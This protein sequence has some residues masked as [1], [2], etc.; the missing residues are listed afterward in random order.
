MAALHM[1]AVM[2]ALAMVLGMAAARTAAAM[3][4]VR[5]AAA[6][7]VGTAVTACTEED[8]HLVDQWEAPC[9]VQVLMVVGMAA[10]T[11]AG[12]AAITVVM[13]LEP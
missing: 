7:V 6:T 11:V 13:V 1:A 2:G 12:M 9:M 3:G 4:L 10:V 8:P 5:M